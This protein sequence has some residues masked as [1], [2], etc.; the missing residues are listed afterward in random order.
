MHVRRGVEL[1]RLLTTPRPVYKT[2][3]ELKPL[4]L[5]P[6][7]TGEMESSWDELQDEPQDEPA[8]VSIKFI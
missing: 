2:R 6:S 3:E 4:V 7:S 5:T 1:P 8:Q